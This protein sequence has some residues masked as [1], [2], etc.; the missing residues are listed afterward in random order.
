MLSRKP[1]E[2]AFP[3]VQKSH[4]HDHDGGFDFH[5]IFKLLIEF[6]CQDIQGYIDRVIVYIADAHGNYFPPFRTIGQPY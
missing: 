6:W 3:S 4:F 5:V 1:F 2:D